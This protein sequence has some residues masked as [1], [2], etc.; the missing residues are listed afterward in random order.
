M[1]QQPKDFTEY[2]YTWN[3]VIGQNP[4]RITVLA[5]DVEHAKRKAWALLHKA[6]NQVEESNNVTGHEQK[7]GA[8]T[9]KYVLFQ[10]GNYCQNLETVL[11]EFK[12]V[13]YDIEPK[14]FHKNALIVTS[15]QSFDMGSSGMQTARSFAFD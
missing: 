15:C 4:H 14:K 13:M 1:M 3:F 10:Q 8:G 11:E 7:S 6:K 2:Y 9:S 12:K 5:R